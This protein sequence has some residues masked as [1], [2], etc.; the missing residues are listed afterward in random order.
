MAVKATENKPKERDV[1]FPVVPTIVYEQDERVTTRDILPNVV[2]TQMLNPDID[3]EASDTTNDIRI[4]KTDPALIFMSPITLETGYWMG[5]D[6][7]A[8]GDDDDVFQFG[9]GTTKFVTPIYYINQKRQ[10]GIGTNTS[11]KGDVGTGV[12]AALNFDGL[13]M[14][15]ANDTGLTGINGD[16]YGDGLQWYA[17]TTLRFSQHMDSNGNFYMQYLNSP[18]LP[19]SKYNMISFLRNYGTTPEMSILESAN[20]NLTIGANST[21]FSGG[22]TYLNLGVGNIGYYFYYSS[23]NY[24]IITADSLPVP[25]YF[26]FGSQTTNIGSRFFG[27]DTTNPIIILD[28]LTGTVIINE[29]GANDIDVRMEGDTDANL[30][31]LKASTDRVGIGTNAPAE[32]F[33]VAGNVQIGVGAAGVDCYLKFDGET[34]DGI[35]TW[36]ED[37]NW[38]KHNAVTRTATSLYKRYYHMPLYSSDPG[39]SGATFTPATANH[40]TGW[41]LNAATE[42]LYFQSDVHSDWD[43]ATDLNVEVKFVLL[44]AG[45]ANDTV[46]L[47]LVCHYNGVGDTAIKTQTVEVATTTDGTQYKV[48]KAIFTIDFDAVSNV[49]DA[50]DVICFMLN[51]ETDTSEIDNILV[52]DASFYYSTTHT[53]IESA[54]V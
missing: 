41:Q 50:G 49:V 35:I 31:F 7:D 38:F 52:I 2:K 40:V 28:R 32:K 5:I 16:D 33:T 48:Y 23:T 44:D 53:Y 25:T 29:H 39:A 43:G 9:L 17:S 45:V 24:K 15:V 30:F 1:L 27:G 18:A 42:I 34:N 14:M 13:I 12:N 20:A 4:I 36:M 10:I 21:K 51:L 37:E 19:F 11:L 22:G 46:D 6:H 47:K 8:E 3:F 54:D 26:D